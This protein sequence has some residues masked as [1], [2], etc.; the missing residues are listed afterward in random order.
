MT[1]RF[2]DLHLKLTQTRFVYLVNNKLSGI[3]ISPNVSQQILLYHIFFCYFKSEFLRET[4]HF[5]WVNLSANSLAGIVFDGF[6]TCFHLKMLRS[7][8]Y[9]TNDS[10]Q[11]NVSVTSPRKNRPTY[12]HLIFITVH[13]ISSSLFLHICHSERKG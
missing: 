3:L 6:L 13:Y 12:T 2:S 11:I 8:I 1:I 10:I 9:Y 4:G 5:V 7:G